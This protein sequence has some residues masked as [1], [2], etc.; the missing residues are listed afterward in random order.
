M[1]LYRLRSCAVLLGL[2]LFCQLRAAAETLHLRIVG[3][4]GGVHQ[5]IH[6]E[7][8]FWTRELP[9]LSQGRV[10]AEI[11]PFD[12]AGMRGEEVLRLL[13]SGSVPF[14][15][16]LLA[17][18]MAVEPELGAVDL[19][20][21]NPDI[22]TLRRHLAAYRP[23]LEAVLRERHGIEPLA[24]YVYP[25]QVTFCSKPFRG[26]GDL[27]GRR[28]RVAS[29][30]HADLLRALGAQPV[31]TEFAQ[32]VPALRAGTVDCAVTGSMSGHTIG[33]DEVTSHIDASAVSWGL[34]VFGANQ[35]AWS[36]LPADVQQLLRRGLAELERAVWAES[37]RESGEGVA[38][39]TGA[40][41]CQQPRRGRMTLVRAEA[42]DAQ[43]LRQALQ[44]TV[45][46]VWAQRCGAACAAA[47]NRHLAPAVGLRAVTP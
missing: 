2:L 28:V 44:H 14:G 20:G 21:M 22:A 32:I 10:T 36:A 42:G 46:P 39:L 37:E 41:A 26:L 17:R 43:R 34:A 18:T 7:A 40:P 38:C 35:V 15:T 45:L 25:A 29:P 13:A 24:I 3:G 4:L 19:P 5:Y 47:W 9:R 16:V 33:L 8:P 11:V 6:Q 30:A 23:H 31:Q 27:A 12:H 1:K